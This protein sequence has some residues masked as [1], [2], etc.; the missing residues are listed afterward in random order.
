M[1]D[2]LKRHA[3]PATIMAALSTRALVSV[4]A[5]IGCM[6]MLFM[7]PFDYAIASVN[8]AIMAACLMIYCPS[9]Q[10]LSN[11]PA[12]HLSGLALKFL[13]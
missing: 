4:P 11:S 7:I 3:V 1:S 6:A 13:L 9:S 2:M 12:T 5:L 8:M 10:A